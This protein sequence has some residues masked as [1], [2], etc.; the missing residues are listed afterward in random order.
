MYKG[1]GWQYLLLSWIKYARRP[2]KSRG[3]VI[4]DIVGLHSPTLLYVCLLGVSFLVNRQMQL[5]LT[6]PTSVVWTGQLRSP[7]F[8]C[9]WS[10]S[11]SP[12]LPLRTHCG[13]WTQAMTASFTAWPT[14]AWRWTSCIAST[15]FFFYSFIFSLSLPVESPRSR[16]HGVPS[17]CSGVLMC[18]A[19]GV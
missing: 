14:S 10:S 18:T 4:N 5:A 7:W 3:S 16:T 6:W 13:T 1:N 12:C 15:L 2:C 9:W 11:F 17:Y 8:C 19:G